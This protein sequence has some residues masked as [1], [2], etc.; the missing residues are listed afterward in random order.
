MDATA[1]NLRSARGSR[2]DTLLT[3]H[4][5]SYRPDSFMLTGLFVGLH[6]D[7]VVSYFLVYANEEQ[8]YLSQV[9]KPLKLTFLILFDLALV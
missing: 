1:N 5:V 4:L 3:C 2:G 8:S 6:N 7:I 9:N